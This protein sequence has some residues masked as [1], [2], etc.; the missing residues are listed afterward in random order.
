MGAHVSFQTLTCVLMIYCFLLSFDFAD[1][2]VPLKVKLKLPGAL[3]NQVLV[4]SLFER[5]KEPKK[6]P[7]QSKYGVVYVYLLGF[8][9]LSYLLSLHC[10]Y[11]YISFHFT[12]VFF[13]SFCC[14]NLFIVIC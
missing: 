12:V 3:L 1:T 4:S 11:I 14:L 6:H 9:C 10:L 7:A 8:L 13:V 2:A 5:K